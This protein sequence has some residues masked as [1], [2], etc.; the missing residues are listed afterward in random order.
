PMPVPARTIWDT[1]LQCVCAVVSA[2]GPHGIELYLCGNFAQA[3]LDPPRIVINPSRL[4]PIEGTIQ[5]AGRF[6]V[7]VIPA[8]CRKQ[9]EALYG[10]RRRQPHKDRFLGFVC[11]SD[12][13]GIPFLP[14]ALRTLFCEV[15][16][17]HDTGDHTLVV[18][19][20]VDTRVNAARPGELPLL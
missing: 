18:A 11:D 19:R 10:L 15:E 5:W 13:R 20:V 1:R 3:T 9:A 6:A 12:A 8:S 14:D 4:Y 7:N 16:S 2:K 17:V